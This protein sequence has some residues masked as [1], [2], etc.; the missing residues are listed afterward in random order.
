LENKCDETLSENKKEVEGLMKGVYTI[1][2]NLKSEI[3]EDDIRFDKEILQAK[4]K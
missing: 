3:E 1:M 4:E 2:L